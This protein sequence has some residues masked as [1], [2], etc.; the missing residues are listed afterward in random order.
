MA[1][2]GGQTDTAS[3]SARTPFLGPQTDTTAFGSSK[4][5]HSVWGAQEDEPR[6][7]Q[8]I[9][10]GTPLVYVWDLGGTIGCQSPTGFYVSV[11]PPFMCI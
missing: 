2:D 10:F 5:D 6:S 8:N 4:L 9:I 1:Q 11:N 7:S 3:T